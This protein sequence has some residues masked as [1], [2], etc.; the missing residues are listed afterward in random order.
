MEAL[1]G[2]L[3]DPQVDD[4][5]GCLGQ[6]CMPQAKRKKTHKVPESRPCNICDQHT[7]NWGAGKKG[8][9]STATATSRAADVTQKDKAS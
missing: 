3:D 1:E 4:P 7:T 5:V 8:I 2:P 6:P 9:A